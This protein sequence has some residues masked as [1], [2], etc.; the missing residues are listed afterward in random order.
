[1][2]LAFTPTATGTRTGTLTIVDSDPSSPQIINL[3]GQAT[4]ISFS[5]APVNLRR[6]AVH[7]LSRSRGFGE[8]DHRQSDPHQQRDFPPLYFEHWI[9][10]EFASQYSV[11]GQLCGPHRSRRQVP[12]TTVFKPTISGFIPAPSNHHQQRSA[13]SGNTLLAGPRYPDSCGCRSYSASANLGFRQP[14][15]N[16]TVRTR[17]DGG[18]LSGGISTSLL[19]CNGR[20]LYLLQPDNIA[21]QALRADNR[22]PLLFPSL[23]RPPALSQELCL[24]SDSD[25]GTSPQPVTLK[26]QRRGSAKKHGLRAIREAG[27][28][29]L[30]RRAI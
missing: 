14:P 9:G 10:G 4:N 6:Q 7:R 13:E 19:E 28:E 1:L 25:P 24:L 21:D 30:W 27:R 12:L 8:H 2:N 22:A 3:T 11:D 18:S 15:Q 16:V 26:W 29:R 17:E 5:T 20:N 23:R